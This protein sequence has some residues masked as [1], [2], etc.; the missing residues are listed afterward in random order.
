[1]DSETTI[2][3]RVIDHGD[4]SSTVSAQASDGQILA[5]IGGRYVHY[6]DTGVSSL[7]GDSVAKF[8]RERGLGWAEGA[9]T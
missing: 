5:S 9:T 4:G 3:I 6:S 1:M 8:L 2:T 7:V